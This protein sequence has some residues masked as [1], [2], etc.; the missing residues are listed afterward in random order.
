MAS[1]AGIAAR[2]RR[3]RLAHSRS[4][5]ALPSLQASPVCDV[6]GQSGK[7]VTFMPGLE[8]TCDA[9]GEQSATAVQRRRD[10]PLAEH[11]SIGAAELRAEKLTRELNF[12]HP[13]TWRRTSTQIRLIISPPQ[14]YCSGRRCSQSPQVRSHRSISGKDD[15]SGVNDLDVNGSR[16]PKSFA[17]HGCSPGI[18]GRAAR[19]IVERR[20]GSAAIPPYLPYSFALWRQLWPGLRLTSADRR[21]LAAN[22]A[23]RSLLHVQLS[24]RA[25][26]FWATFVSH[27]GLVSTYFS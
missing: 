21:G 3:W 10:R 17:H 9:A 18:A 15:G 11:R 6:A 7:A 13:S 14:F 1:L 25:S 8:L 22:K 16:Q 19:S 5:P 20:N 27:P 24:L 23:H 2:V 4:A 26:A 12:A